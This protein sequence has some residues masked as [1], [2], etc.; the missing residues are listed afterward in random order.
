M[1]SLR[2]VAAT[3]KYICHWCDKIV[4]L[5][6]NPDHPEAATREHIIPESVRKAGT[7]RA[8]VLAHKKCNGLR[9]NA[10]A[11]AFKRLMNGEAVTKFELWP[12]LFKQ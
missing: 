7:P 6:Y 4:S 12:H 3:A 8:Y 5:R 1:P 2:E 9:G 11:E 10:E